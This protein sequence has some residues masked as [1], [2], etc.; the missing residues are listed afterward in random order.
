[1]A[2]LNDV[3]FQST[4]A[5]TSDF[6]IG[7]AMDGGYQVPSSAAGFVSGSTYSYSARNQSG[8]Q[9]ESGTGA[10]DGSTIA[11][12]HVIDGSSGAGVKVNFATAPTVVI[13]A[14]ADDL[15]AFAQ[16]SLLPRLKYTAAK[17]FSGAAVTGEPPNIDYTTSQPN[18]LVMACFGDSTGED[19]SQYVG[20]RLNRAFGAGVGGFLSN[21]TLAGGATAHSDV[22]DCSYWIN[23]D[24]YVIPS[25]GSALF[26]QASTAS[27]YCTSLKLYYVKR[28]GAGTFKVQIDGVDQGAPYNNV[29]AANATTTA[30]VITITVAAGRHNI[31]VIGLT[32]TVEI[33]Q[34]ASVDASQAGLAYYSLARHSLE[35]DTATTTPVAIVNVVLGD[36]SPDLFTMQFVHT[37]NFAAAFAS[38]TANGLAN[39]GTKD[40]LLIGGNPQ[41]NSSND[42]AVVADNAIQR[43]WA[44]A[45]GRAYFDGHDIFAFPGGTA[46]AG[47]VSLGWQGDG[48]HSAQAAYTF[49]GSLLYQYCGFDQ[50]FNTFQTRDT[51][52]NNIYALQQ[53]SI[54]SVT[55]PYAV[56]TSDAFATDLQ[57]R[58]TRNVYMTDPTGATPFAC[59]SGAQGTFDTYFK[60]SSGKFGVNTDAPNYAMTV[61]GRFEIVDGEPTIQFSPT[62][63]SGLTRNWALSSN[64]FGAG[65]S[66][67][68]YSV[69][70]AESGDPLGGSAVVS[71]GFEK[72]GTQIFFGYADTQN[73]SVLQSGGPVFTKNYIVSGLPSASGAGVGARAFVTDSTQTLAAGIGSTVAG[74][75]GNKVPVYSDGTNWK[76][77]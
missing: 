6:G 61:E 7:A 46:Y 30:G 60:P 67:F 45:N 59:I 3:W 66:T 32:G 20:N 62:P 26:K 41:S 58:T 40:W 54:G 77:G 5:G 74:T 12:T 72:S 70:A 49:L 11:R 4:T 56:L 17:I 33:I 75:G 22:T 44:Q 8:T 16:V 65:F 1:M 68:A 10:C 36:I 19:V 53:V 37:T 2:F 51:I 50:L 13:A 9:F 71:G 38:F 28:S 35:L 15:D 34:A 64:H 31:G 55:A 47:L 73:S 43:A 39:W 14:L 29:N 21:V 23:G 52:A 25:G 69:S 42:A 76:I 57:I 27:P 24:W 63:F 48:V 18:T